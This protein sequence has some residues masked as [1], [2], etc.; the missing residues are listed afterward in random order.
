MQMTYVAAARG[1]DTPGFVAAGVETDQGPGSV[2]AADELARVLM[3]SPLY[4]V[5]LAD[6]SGH[7]RYVNAMAERASGWSE[8]QAR[9]KPVAEVLRLVD[10]PTQAPMP[11]PVTRVLAEDSPIRFGA[12]SLVSCE[13]WRTPVQ[14]IAAPLRARDRTLSGAVLVFQDMTEL[15]QLER[16][17]AYHSRH[18]P[19]TGLVKR[20]AFERALAR[21]ESAGEPGARALL[22]LHLDNLAALNETLGRNVGDGVL[23]AITALLEYKARGGDVVARLGGDEFGMLLKDC[24]REQAVALAREIVAEA[25]GLWQARSVQAD[26][27]GPCLCVGVATLTSRAASP[28][29]V[30][31][32]AA[33]EAA[34]AQGRNRVSVWQDRDGD[35]AERRLALHWVPR[36]NA[37]WRDHRFS[38]RLQEIRPLAPRS[39]PTHY[40]V[41]LRMQDE[42]GQEVPPSEFIP[43]AERYGLMPELDR[44][45][46]R[47]VFEMLGRSGSNSGRA[48]GATY[49]INLS[50][51]SLNDPTLLDYIRDELARVRLPA[52][53]ICFEIT[54]TSAVTNLR[55]AGALTRS[56][57][58]LG[59]KLA[60]DDFGA[61][62]SSF[63]YLK[64]LAVDYLKIEGSFVRDVATNRESRAIVEAINNVGHALGLRTIA[65][66]VENR[67]AL[68]E[69]REI[70]VDFAQGYGVARP[71]P[72]SG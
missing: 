10:S 6:R 21:A 19:L 20:A 56:L 55:E 43:V 58:A 38:F 12:A 7:V 5:I 67:A 69:L 17:L 51:A 62:L 44:W 30:A 35:A 28:A 27:V 54:E 48:L 13:G 29:L 11:C 36:I 15:R 3:E 14:G 42:R 61:G 37:A 45:I 70:G 8:A 68:L 41:L 47:S 52:Q 60:L 66:C 26:G 32:Q 72:L 53:A 57:K 24:S 4:G 46:I 71:Q 39:A 31:A 65:E 63:A 23:R 1:E 64:S 25:D 59:F 50:G 49:C 40:E 2:A 22:F 34:R 33:C 16:H 18:D 9:G